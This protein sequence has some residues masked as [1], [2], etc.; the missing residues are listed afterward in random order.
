MQEKEFKKLLNKYFDGSLSEEEEELL[1]KFKEVLKS[2]NETHF[3]NGAEKN[4]IEKS[5]W[6][7]INSEISSS[8]ENR[9]FANWKIVA[10]AA[11][12]IGFTVTGYFYLQN[13]GF[14]TPVTIP[15][16]VITL[17][18]EDGS[19]K[20]IEENQTTKVTDKTGNVVG[21]Q[22]G[23]Q[24]VYKETSDV[25]KLVYNTLTVPYGKNFE[26]QL[27]DGT[28]AHLN[29]GSSLKYPV[30]FLKGKE[31][32]VFITGEAYLN[33]AK[34]SVHPFIVNTD[35]LSIRVLGTQF[36]VTAYPEDDATDIV[37]VEGL[38]SLYTEVIGFDMEKNTLLKPGFKGSFDRK[39][40]SITSKAVITSTYTSWMDGELV[41]RNMSFGNILK[42]LER[43][44]DVIIVNNNMELSQ[45]YFNANFGSESIGNVL[46]ELKMNYGIDYA[47]SGDE[48][49][50]N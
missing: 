39:K 12:F 17:Q 15:E 48:I 22:K 44:F 34:D 16:N 43:H 37:L 11:V 2:N 35:E 7:G 38:V 3:Q 21:L 26:L 45:E 46:E 25:E 50:I 9:K 29:A 1:D 28:T 41:F 18:L 6:S 31:R 33:V 23:N 14:N 49:I 27:S 32:H 10:S 40:N 24:L 4:N 30:K 36:N 42:K 13:Q 47:V 8:F 5:L 19:I 20:I